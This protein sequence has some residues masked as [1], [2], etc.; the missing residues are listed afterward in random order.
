MVKGK[1]NHGAKMK[2]GKIFRVGETPVFLKSV[3]KIKEKIGDF[4][5]GSGIG[6]SSI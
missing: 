4:L 2:G 1:R 5:Q 3:K 6:D